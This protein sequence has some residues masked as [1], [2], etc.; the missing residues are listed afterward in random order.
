MQADDFNFYRNIKYVQI[1]AGV[2]REGCQIS[3]VKRQ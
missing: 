3:I 1:F 2:P